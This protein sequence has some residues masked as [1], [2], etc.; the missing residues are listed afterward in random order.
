MAK[1]Q[2]NTTASLPA[3]AVIKTLV[4]TPSRVDSADIGTWK[5]ALNNAMRSGDRSRFYDL[6]D[7]VMLDGVLSSAVE[8]RVNKI[9]NAE[10]TFQVKGESVEEI[11]DLIDTPEFEELISQIALSRAY[12][13]SVIELGFTPDF[14]VF[15][16]PRKNIKITNL[17]KPLSERKRFI[18]AKP[19]DRDGY[20][21][22]QDEFIIECGKDDDLGYIFKAA[23]YVIYKRGGFG[24]WAQYAEI[25]GMPFIWATYNSAD[26]RQRDMLFDA[27]SKVGS[28]P[29]AAVPDGTNLNVHD[30]GGKSTDLF[31]RFK[32]ACDEEILIAVL[33][34]TMTTSDGSSRSQAEV[35][36][37]TE[38]GIAQSDRRYVQRM[39]NKYL[40]PLLVKRGYP[41]KGGFFLFPDQGEDISTKD[42][43]DMAFRMRGEG[44]PVDDDYFY[45][46][47]GIPK[48]EQSDPKEKKEG[49]AKND[50][51]SDDPEGTDDPPKEKKETEPAKKETTLSEGDKNWFLKL[52]D[53]FF[54]Y[55]PTKEERGYKRS[56]WTR[57]T[58]SITGKITLADDYAIDIS[59][60]LQ[61]AL[62]EVYGNAK[63]GKEQPIVSKPLFDITNDALQ[64]AVESVFTPE[65]GEKNE[66]FVAEFSK[67]TAVF[68]AFKNH[69]QTN[70][71]VALLLDEDGDLRSFREFKKLALKVSKNY[72]EN[73]LQ[74][75][76]NTAVRSARS[77]ANYR[78]YL[79]TKDLYPN[80]EYIQS[81][82]AHP[83]E[84]H[85]AYVGTILPIEH[86]WWDTH[87]PPSDWGCSCSVRPTDKKVTAV[88]A[89]ELVPPVFQNNPGKSAE[90]VKLKEHPYVK[91]V[92]PDF[93]GCKPE[94]NLADGGDEPICK[95]I[96]KIAK[97]YQAETKKTAIARKRNSLLKSMTILLNRNVTRYVGSGKHIKIKFNAKGNSH[98]V[99]DYLRGLSGFDK[100]E[101]M[102]LDKLLKD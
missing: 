53:G 92:C 99:N 6:L 87:M 102:I 42:R 18:A 52:L 27:L 24:D 95:K 70:E 8:R 31:D 90:F 22:T 35:H 86:V 17:E 93:N 61:Q 20:D 65:F 82:A 47:T 15:S 34:Q 63:T 80:L 2:A 23:A 40:V 101:M 3:Q 59:K 5:T 41:V 13:K 71:L 66:E 45:E 16:F 39:L 33:G 68:A 29:V 81:T 74:T 14:E 37:D 44:I 77:A 46:I 97:E 75:E 85:L 57:L 67:N 88:P 21:Y 54:A 98:V 91:K 7:N 28:N 96:C 50:D 26:E 55:A 11:D 19:S 58:D 73:W 60:L 12:G 100:Q 62:K 30:V 1:K 79:E 76:Y 56:L 36:Q 9:T 69:E 49:K 84:S 43:L 89:G 64:D 38:E 78:R 72:N 83:R 51:D 94:T 25:F 32:K 48:A 4:V 10:I